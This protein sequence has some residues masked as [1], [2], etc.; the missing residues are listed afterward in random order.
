MNEVARE[1]GSFSK[2]EKR[3]ADLRKKDEENQELKK[4]LREKAENLKN[5]AEANSSKMSE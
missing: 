1:R 5:D 4:Q 3:F 2:T